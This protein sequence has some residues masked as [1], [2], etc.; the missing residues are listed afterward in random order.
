MKSHSW[1]TQ[2]FSF[3]D[4]LETSS[5]WRGAS[6]FLT[7]ID[8]RLLVDHLLMFWKLPALGAVQVT[9]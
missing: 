9:F 1:I 5:T 2:M 4:F 7:E 8:R 6:Y 3:I